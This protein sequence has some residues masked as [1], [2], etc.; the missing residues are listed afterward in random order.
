MYMYMNI[1][2]KHLCGNN[3][4]VTILYNTSIMCVHKFNVLCTL[5][6]HSTLKVHCFL[7]LSWALNLMCM[8]VTSVSTFLSS[9]AMSV[10]S[11]Y[12]FRNPIY[13][14]WFDVD[15]MAWV[16][17]MKRLGLLLVTGNHKI[18]HS[19]HICWLMHTP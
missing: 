19:W 1:I 9:N 17:K 7:G 10:C 18:N 11:D 3:V 8:L 13:S 2:C 15:L 4:M 6:Q 5:N 14:F 12:L 16:S